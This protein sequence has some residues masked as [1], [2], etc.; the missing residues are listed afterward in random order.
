MREVCRR[1]SKTRKRK[2]KVKGE[3]KNESEKAS[4]QEK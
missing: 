4:R 1:G 3:A 2:V